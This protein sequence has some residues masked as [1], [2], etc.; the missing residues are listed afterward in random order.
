MLVP[1]CRAVVGATNPE[2]HQQHH[3]QF[4]GGLSTLPAFR[5]EPER[6]WRRKIDPKLLQHFRSQI[7]ESS[8]CQS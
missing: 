3:Q 5:D 8:V 6:G 2:Q 1:G 7:T 4:V